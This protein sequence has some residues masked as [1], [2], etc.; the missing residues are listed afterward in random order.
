MKVNDD[1][2]SNIM[3]YN[4]KVIINIKRNFFIIFKITSNILVHIST[5]L[6]KLESK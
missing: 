6:L 5:L 1:S 3:I 4:S 2:I